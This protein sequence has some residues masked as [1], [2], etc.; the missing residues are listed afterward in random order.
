MTM[1]AVYTFFYKIL[2][3]RV[4]CSWNKSHA[5]QMDRLLF[6]WGLFQV[7]F[8]RQNYICW[9]YVALKNE[10]ACALCWAHPPDFPAFQKCG[11]VS[12]GP[13]A[14]PQH[15]RCPLAEKED[16]SSPLS[17]SVGNTAALTS[18]TRAEKQTYE[19]LGLNVFEGFKG[20]VRTKI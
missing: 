5:S 15:C 14:R 10:I 7:S 13:R 17:L 2:W 1:Q 11:S 16:W 9:K 3:R 4:N 8:S 18:N 19:L 12:P 20:I 6:G